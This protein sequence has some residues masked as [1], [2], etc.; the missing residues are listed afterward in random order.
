MVPIY[1]TIQ[2]LKEK[3]RGWTERSYHPRRGPDF[4]VCLEKRKAGKMRTSR[5]ISHVGLEH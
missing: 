4:V 3:E 1:A 2:R 5:E